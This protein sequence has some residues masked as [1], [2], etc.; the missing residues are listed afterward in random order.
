M[1]GAEWSG[2][3][4]A[5]ANPGLSVQDFMYSLLHE[6]EAVALALQEQFDR[7]EWATARAGQSSG[8]GAGSGAGGGSGV[9]VGS[10]GEAGYEV[11]GSEG[12]SG[13]GSSGA[14]GYNAGSSHGAGSANDDWE[15]D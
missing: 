10:Y 9:G 3:K 7:E 5:K 2:A 11:R 12:G 8:R 14:A 15:A 1:D 13:G 4:K 6:D